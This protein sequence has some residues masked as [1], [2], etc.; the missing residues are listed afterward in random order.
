[1]P[2]TLRA[3]KYELFSFPR[4]LHEKATQLPSGEISPPL[5]PFGEHGVLKASS[6][7]SA[8]SV[9]LR[10]GDGVG[11]GVIV[12]VLDG[13]SAETVA[14]WFRIPVTVPMICAPWVWA[15]SGV[16]GVAGGEGVSVGEGDGVIEIVG[17]GVGMSNVALGIWFWG[18][19]HPASKMKIVMKRTRIFLDGIVKRE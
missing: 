13:V 2:S 9:G 14:V 18:V 15:F 16:A 7:A 1:M 8:S 11:D 4:A 10:I 5:F 12:G 17:L 19:E 3:T 6:V